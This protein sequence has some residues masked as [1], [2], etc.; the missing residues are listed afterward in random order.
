MPD[1][2]PAVNGGAH[3]LSPDDVPPARAC[4]ICVH[5]CGCRSDGTTHWCGSVAH[6]MPGYRIVGTHD[7]LTAYR[8]RPPSDLLTD[9][10]RRHVREFLREHADR[11]ADERERA[12]TCAAV[13][14]AGLAALPPEEVAAAI[15]EAV[16][17]SDA[18]ADLRRDVTQIA[19]AV[20]AGGLA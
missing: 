3:A 5:A 14:R 20:V 4:D 1:T 15:A 17:A 10:Q 7:G 16:E 19:A 8:R 2:T 11:A 12:A 9:E 6:E 18:V 13:V